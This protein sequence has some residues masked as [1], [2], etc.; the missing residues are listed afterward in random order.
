MDI[1]SHGLWGGL[2]FG[3][4]SKKTFAVTMLFGMLPDAIPF[5]VPFLAFMGKSIVSG[6][7]F[8]APIPGEGYAGMPAYVHEF[9]AVTHSLVI[10][11]V[12][13]VIV[14]LMRKRPYLPL[15][16]WGLHVLMDIPVH[17]RAFFPTP[18]L[19]PISDYTFDGINWSHAV[20]FLP[21][22]LVLA[23]CCAWFWRNREVP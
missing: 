11:V 23:L 21:N 22:I 1:L 7:I 16:S 4:K 12:V 19:W 15:A 14:A 20:I 17:T 2:A 6:A 13:F 9:Y 10:F 3:R 5:G 18:F 8:R